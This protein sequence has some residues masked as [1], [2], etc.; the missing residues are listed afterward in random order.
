[1]GEPTPLHQPV[2]LAVLPLKTAAFRRPS[3]SVISPRLMVAVSVLN[4]QTAATLPL[5]FTLPSAAKAAAGA[6]TTARAA[7]AIRVF[8]LF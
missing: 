7:R 2:R 8:I 1:M 4:L 3:L 5:M 6:E